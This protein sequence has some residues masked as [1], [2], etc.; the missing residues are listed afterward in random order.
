MF[1]KMT[2]FTIRRDAVEIL[3]GDLLKTASL[4]LPNGVVY[5]P[6]FFYMKVRGV[7]AGE[8]WG[9]NK[10]FDF[11]PEAELKTSYMTFLTAHTFKNHENKDIKNA[12]GDVLTAE[13]NDKMKG[14]DL[15]L[16]IDRKIAPT[17]VRGFEKG[18]MTDVS[19]GCRI[20]HSVC[21]ICG[22]KAKTK[23]EYCD[24]IKLQ[25]GKILDDGRKVYEIN[26]GPKF[27]DI[28]AVLNGAE[29]AA[30]VIGLMIVDGKVAFEEGET[31]LE[32]VASFQESV[33][34]IFTEETSE[35]HHGQKIASAVDT[36]DLDM[37][38]YKTMDKKAYVQ[39][40]AEIK[41]DLQGK[42]LNI[43]KG[44]Y[45]QERQ[46]NADAM[47]ETL[48][49]LGENFWDRE[50][51][52][53]IAK[54]IKYL[55]EQRAM[56]LEAAFD[57]FIKVL[58]FA[59]IELTPLELHDISSALM[60]DVTPDLRQFNIPS[61]ENCGLSEEM[62]Q[63]INGNSMEEHMNLPTL[64]RTILESFGPNQTKILAAL[65]PDTE[66]SLQKMK[67]TIVLIKKNAPSLND[68]MMQMDIMSHIVKSLMAERSMHRNHLIPRL[69]KMIKNGPTLNPRNMSHFA[70]V[71]LLGSESKLPIS[72]VASTVPYI[73]SGLMYSTYQDE[74]VASYLNGELQSGISKFAGDIY[75]ND[76]YKTA[77][78]KPWGSG[79]AI[80]IGIPAAYAYS[81]IQ[82]AR[83]NNGER[84]NTV[85]RFA[86][87]NPGSTAILQLAFAPTVAKGLS[88]LKA[89]NIGGLDTLDNFLYKKF[90]S[91][92]NENE[93]EKTALF[94]NGKS[95]LY[96]GDMFK[97]SDIDSV[98][99]KHYSENQLG[100]IKQ[101]CIL[102]A[103]Q[104]QDVANDILYKHSLLEE[105][106]AEYLKTASDCIK[107]G[108]E[109]IADAEFNKQ[110]V[111]NAAGDVLFNPR[112]TSLLA[113]F[114]G[115]L[116][117]SFVLTKLLNKSK[118]G[119]SPAIKNEAAIVPTTEPLK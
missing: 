77:S 82:R 35:E 12:I 48:K 7:S 64:F 118:Q 25:R 53:E 94:D 6:D 22:N 80:L 110:M 17:I 81:G 83:I 74:R 104:K 57:Q 1:N 38:M 106:L 3:D 24:H 75:G 52:F 107:I 105:D 37:N 95:S 112:G 28:S 30:K 84:V 91:N 46:E 36:I 85:N 88:K 76:I 67:S 97:D 86:A 90:A 41:K 20:S 33:S 71:K 44:E 114:P 16:R 42:I 60:G 18:F 31:S 68:D 19:M 78:K 93:Q 98:M 29:R 59:G 15:L 4:K 70:P 101:A 96:N 26:I 8:F 109:K 99:L 108:I 56:P 87:E 49:L 89:K 100:A 14:V 2:T 79:K 51:C 61:V 47:A 69:E 116:I 45:I 9:C 32:K 40:I 73:L 50:K 92:L 58:N 72:K 10:N 113:S 11:F 27:H 111:A 103:M 21:S 117:D 63:I 5:D 62:D 23:Y 39:K 115:N 54:K 34:S 119:A 65:N 102:T 43:A 55:A 13:W 66:N